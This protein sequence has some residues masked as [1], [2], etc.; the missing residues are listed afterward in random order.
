MQHTLAI[1]PTTKRK[2]WFTEHNTLERLRKA[3]HSA[4]KAH[5]ILLDAIRG[6]RYA[7]AWI[8]SATGES[9]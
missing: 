3:G 5:M 1:Y 8:L 4:F 6:D 9:L 7:I 2:A